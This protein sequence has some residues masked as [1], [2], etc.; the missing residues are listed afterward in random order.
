M[1]V[2]TKKIATLAVQREKSAELT[3]QRET[4]LAVRREASVEFVD[5]VRSKSSAAA[6]LAFDLPTFAA[7]LAVVVFRWRLET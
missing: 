1:P 6:S 7:L 3:V 5:L 2:Q 4:E